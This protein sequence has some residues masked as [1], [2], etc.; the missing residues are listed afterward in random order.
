[1]YPFPL[2]SRQ[3]NC[4]AFNV[5]EAGTK[6]HWRELRGKCSF[7]LH[8]CISVADYIRVNGIEQINSYRARLGRRWVV[9]L[10]IHGSEILVILMVIKL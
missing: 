2:D 8:S 6:N 4:A 10:N 3:E 7:T 5:R 9:E 1:M